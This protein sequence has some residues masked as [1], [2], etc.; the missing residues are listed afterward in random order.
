MKTLNNLRSVSSYYFRKEIHP[1]KGQRLSKPKVHLKS[2][3]LQGTVKSELQNMKKY[4]SVDL[5]PKQFF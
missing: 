3:S 4:F 5:R 1:G 2:S